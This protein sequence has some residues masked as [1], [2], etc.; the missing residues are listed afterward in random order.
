MNA[1]LLPCLLRRIIFGFIAMAPV[2]LMGAIL[3]A[4][5]NPARADSGSVAT[6]NGS[7]YVSG[8]HP[9]VRSL[10]RNV[11][12]DGSQYPSDLSTTNGGIYVDSGQKAGRV[13][14]VNGGIHIG[15]DATV[16]PVTT[17]N[18]GV[19]LGSD[20]TAQSL[21]TVNGS[22]SVGPGT[23]IKGEVR[24]VN[25][26]FNFAQGVDIAGDLANVN[27]RMRLLGVHIG[28]S[29]QTHT[30][31]IYVGPGSRIDGDLRVSA[32]NFSN[33]PGNWFFRLIFGNYNGPDQHIPT[34][35][36]APGA[37]VTGTLHFEREVHLYVSNR[38]KIGPVEGAT[39]SPYA[40]E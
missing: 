2:L 22:I 3:A 16:G 10:N 34:I 39:P 9:D 31:D 37:V 12:V 32:F 40:G 8:E 25:G 20:A 26:G 13:R 15:S 6:V 11:E 17:V 7:I 35:I 18:G 4:A 33:G 24:T 23:H 36:I 21:R 5:A 1:Q 28:G 27:G 29:V 30:G 14:A 38:A 19:T